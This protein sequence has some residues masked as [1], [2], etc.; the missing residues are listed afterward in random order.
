MNIDLS[1]AFTASTAKVLTTMALLECK[2]GEPT[3]HKDGNEF[4]DVTGLIGLA[5]GT[6]KGV[7]AISFPRTVIFDI[8]LRMLG[9][10]VF[11]IDDTVTDLVGELTNMITGGAKVIL[12]EG[13]YS[14]DMA[15]PLVI[16]GYAHQI[17]NKSRGAMVVPFYT[18]VGEF[19]IEVCFEES[20]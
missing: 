13:N 2:P 18:S 15:L 8:T 7:F 5:G 14:F 12:G 17:T 10:E 20:T 11:E 1:A 19:F 4:A 6:T 3:L 16:S 9:E